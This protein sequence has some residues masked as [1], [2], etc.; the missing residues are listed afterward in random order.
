MNIKDLIINV[1]KK[2]KSSAK[3]IEK[4]SAKTKPKSEI[5]NP[6]V[7]GAEGR[8]E[9]N[10]RYMN[11]AQSVH[12]WQM[13]FIAVAVIA[14]ILAI[15][16]IKIATQS[17]IKPYIVETSNGMPIAIKSLAST[18]LEDER[19]ANFAINQFVINSKSI[20]ADT[21]AEK[22]M[23]DKVYA[24]SAGNTLNFLQKFYKKNNPF[25]LAGD[26]TITVNIINSMPISKTTWQVTWDETKRS[27]Q[28][29]NII[30]TTRWMADITYSFGAINNKVLN[31]NPFGIYITNVTW[32]QSR[33]VH[34]Q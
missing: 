5:Q 10:D 1:V 23:L 18:N 8:K 28:G 12:N 2:Q 30:D 9:W 29:G 17:R 25:E 15:T 6:Y 4:N 7:L 16:N 20:I 19:I 24:Y 21:A 11:L 27:T 3:S 33:G 34:L 31:E 32:S 22:A 14:L 26:Y 13:A